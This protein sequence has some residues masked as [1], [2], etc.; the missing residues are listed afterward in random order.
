[1]TVN[2][3]IMTGQAHSVAAPLRAASGFKDARTGKSLPG[4]LVPQGSVGQ[5][6]GTDSSGEQ[7]SSRGDE[8]G[9]DEDA[10]SRRLKRLRAP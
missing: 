2:G 6:G 8:R 4:P 9:A 1:M 3:G 7:E 5:D 10:G